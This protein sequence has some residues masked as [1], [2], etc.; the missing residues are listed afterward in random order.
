MKIKDILKKIDFILIGIVLLGFSLR[1]YNYNWD[2]SNLL[3]PDER[4]MVMTLNDIHFTGIDNYFDVKQSTLSPANN[5]KGGYIYGTFPL[6]FMKAVTETFHEIG[7]PKAGVFA[8]LITAMVDSINILVVFLLAKELFS[9]NKGKV[10]HIAALIYSI[11]IFVVQQ[12]H[13][14]TVDTYY[15]F[16]ISIALFVLIKLIK[17]SSNQI[18]ISTILGIVFGLTLASKASA[19]IFMVPI[20]LGFFYRFTKD[21]KSPFKGRKFSIE[22]PTLEFLISGLLFGFYTYCSFRLFQP[23]FFQNSSWLDLT[24]SEQLLGNLKFQQEAMAGKIMFPPQWFWIGKG[25]LHDFIQLAFWYIGIPTMLLFL[26]GAINK[27]FKIGKELKQ[28]AK[29]IFKA[30]NVIHL[31]MFLWIATTY[32]YF[33]KNFVR[34]ARYM[35]ALVPLISIY[36]GYGFIFL[37]NLKTKFFR[38]VAMTLLILSMLF[39]FSFMSIYFNSHT[40]ISASKWI[41]SNIPSSSVLLVEHWDDALPISFSASENY[42]LYTINENKVYDQDTKEKI[43]AMYDTVE[44]SDYIILTSPRAKWSIGKLKDSYP[45]MHNY[46]EN[47]DSGRLGFK[48][49][50]EVHSY[51]SIFGLEI[52]DTS[53][54]EA[55]WVYDHPPVWIYQKER[56]ISYEEFEAVLER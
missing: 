2:N 11:T 20:S 10:A 13:F 5:D 28:N 30:E 35:V 9:K 54:E 45:Y 41:Y 49:V 38:V 48:L 50:K 25:P 12:S 55:F 52:N 31:V 4:F 16:W 3:H 43:K 56:A 24:I 39:T 51:P 8:R 27:V 42:T 40:R 18:L 19:I 7:Y 23:Y 36:A 32:Y 14:Y 6:F 33:G 53:A 44:E 29:H 21:F 1:V 46:Y 47:L 34:P 17:T 37:S 22:S 15:L 26:V